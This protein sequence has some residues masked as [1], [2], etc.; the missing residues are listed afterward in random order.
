MPI[1]DPDKRREYNRKYYQTVDRHKQ[2]QRVKVRRNRLY[3]EF[4]A[5]KSTKSCMHCGES[6]PICLEFHHIDPRTKDVDPADM[7]PNKGWPIDR[8]IRYLETTCIA[9]C[10]NCHKKVHRDLKIL[11]RKL[12]EPSTR[13]PARKS[14][15]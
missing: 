1:K 12:N 7:I 2:K 13:P 6:D 4:N 10:S 5:W 14:R 8:I 11:L 15:R 9:L 3:A